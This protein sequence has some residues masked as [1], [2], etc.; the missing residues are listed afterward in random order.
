M[1]QQ[2]TGDERKR[3]SKKKSKKQ[4]KQQAERG[5]TEGTATHFVILLD[6]SGSM[7]SIADDVLGG[8]NAWVAEQQRDGDDAVLTLVQF[9]S[10]DPQEVVID[11]APIAGVRPLG[12]DR[13]TPR[14]M[15]PLLDATGRVVAMARRRE[16]ERA[17]HGLPAE[18]VVVVSITDGHENSSR[19]FTVS[20]IRDLITER[21]S[22]G[23][24]FVFLSAALDVYGEAGDLGYRAGNVQSFR[25]DA[26]GCDFAFESL[27]QASGRV[28]EQHRTGVVDSELEVW[29][30][31]KPAESDRTERG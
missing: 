17:A 6:R 1:D 3:K 10:Q 24:T 15:T 25:A 21:E 28:R 27:S 26:L 31:D 29:G 30:E 7:E 16:Q 13:F 19:E 14:G 22:A 9:D 8:F 2:Q 18:G 12:R 5:R 20:G 23:W 4:G 11:A